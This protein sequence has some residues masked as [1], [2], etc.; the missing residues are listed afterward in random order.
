MV[1][2]AELTSAFMSEL[3]ALA[4]VSVSTAF[5]N[6]AASRL[7]PFEAR[8][9]SGQIEG[10]ADASLLQTVVLDRLHRLGFESP[11]DQVI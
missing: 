10:F 1:F 3:L 5:L 6:L 4:L 7:M 8:R 9:T 11:R 2:A